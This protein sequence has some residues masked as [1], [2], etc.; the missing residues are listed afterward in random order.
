[1]RDRAAA[2]RAAAR[3]QAVMTGAGSAGVRR[4]ARWGCAVLVALLWLPALIFAAGILVARVTG[5]GATEA[6]PEPCLVAGIDIGHRL[7]AMTM[8]GWVVVGL[9][10]VMLA[11]LVLA[12]VLVVRRL[13]RRRAAGRAYPTSRP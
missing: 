2:R 9:T 8:M 13:V 12:A 7:Y 4:A 6:G 11:S 3:R 1:T 10:P 5:C